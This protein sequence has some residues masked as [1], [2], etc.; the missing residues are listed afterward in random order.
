MPG[1][2]AGRG[3][4]AMCLGRIRRTSRRARDIPSAAST[5][6]Y[7]G[8]ART[9][10]AIDVLGP[11]GP[12]Q[13]VNSLHPAYRREV[14]FREASAQKPKSPQVSTRP[15]RGR[16]CRAPRSG[17]TSEAARP[18]LGISPNVSPACPH[19]TESWKPRVKNSG[20]CRYL[21]RAADR[22]LQRGCSAYSGLAAAL[23]SARR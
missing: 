23:T 22:Q 19:P 6:S 5:R 10:G 11:F 4:A 3:S 9:G 7:P 18:R 21:I 14:P 20:C 13:S 16:P 1:L 2:H 17:I 8:K 15:D 12:D